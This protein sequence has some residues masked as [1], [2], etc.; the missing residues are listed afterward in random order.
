M[1]SFAPCLLS[2]SNFNFP[3]NVSSAECQ[4][5]AE[6]RMLKEQGVLVFLQAK[7]SG[8]VITRQDVIAEKVKSDLS[9]IR[10]SRLK[11][12]DA[13]V[14]FNQNAEWYAK[15]KNRLSTIENQAK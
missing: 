13:N 10:Y 14:I 8:F 4:A 3:S 5:F 12:D 7:S 15:Y 1:K 6:I 11:E 9:G 2:P